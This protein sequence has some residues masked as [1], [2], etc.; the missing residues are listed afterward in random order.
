MIAADL[1][2]SRVAH[3][4]I[5]EFPSLQVSGDT[6]SVLEFVDAKLLTA[7]EKF[8]TLL[9]APV[10]PSPLDEGWVR[11]GGSETSQ[12]YIG[13]IRLDADGEPTSKRLSLA[14]D[15]FPVCDIRHALFTALAIPEFG[16][17]GV[18]LDTKLD[19]KRHAMLHVDLRPG[20]RQIWMRYGG[21]YHYPYRNDRSM[22]LF[23][24]KLAEWQS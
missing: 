24:Q 3:F 6:V 20:P 11:T 1:D 21:T 16:G 22:K 12:H 23:L 2:F 13:P 4:S 7:L 9:G 18:Y 19:G 17:I 8:R 5:G 15:I 14:G 10:R